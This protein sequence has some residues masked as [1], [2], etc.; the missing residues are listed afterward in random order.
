MFS[1]VLAFGLAALALV[2]AAPPSQVPMV[3]CSVN[4][5]TSVGTPKPF[6]TFGVIEP[7][8]YYID[9]VASKTWV[10]S[11]YQEGRPVYVSYLWGEPDISLWKVE[12]VGGSD[13]YRIS[14]YPGGSSAS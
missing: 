14:T 6:N 3:S 12:P 2:H 5:G 1:K 8:I 10:R 13:E 7:G 9:N 11:S 4:I